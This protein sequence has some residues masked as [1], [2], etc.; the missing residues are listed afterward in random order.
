MK[1]GDAIQKAFNFSVVDFNIKND[2]S[3]NA[4]CI[5]ISSSLTSLAAVKTKIVIDKNGKLKCRN[6]NSLM[7]AYIRIHIGMW[8]STEFTDAEITA[9]LLHEIGHCVQYFTN[10][11]IGRFA[12][13]NTIVQNILAFIKNQSKDSN[14]ITNLSS[15]IIVDLIMNPITLSKVNNKIKQNSILS[16]VFG[17]VDTIKGIYIYLLR[18]IFAVFGLSPLTTIK[19]NMHS[20]NNSINYLDPIKIGK[21][22]TRS[23]TGKPS[24]YNADSFAVAFGYSEDLAS[25][26][27]KMNLSHSP[28]GTNIEEIINNIPIIGTINNVSS[29]PFRILMSP[30]EAHPLP[31]KRINAMVVELETELKRSDLS[32]AMKK[33]VKENIKAIKETVDLYTAPKN[34]PDTLK[35]NRKWLQKQI[36]YKSKANKF[37]DMDMVEKEVYEAA[38]VTEY[39]RISALY[40]SLLES[41]FNNEY[42]DDDIDILDWEC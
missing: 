3:L 24:E 1:V 42:E 40:E 37:A 35:Y 8:G 34:T 11:H 27:L 4:Y 9:I 14:I 22:L 13:T 2:S 12:V 29:I 20:L 41:E 5:P 17:T 6:Q 30:F 32:P 16:N 31:P 33:E 19:N 38:I 15:G 28:T 21:K 18:S 25:G 7:C 26:L 23:I 39:I 36:N 10:S